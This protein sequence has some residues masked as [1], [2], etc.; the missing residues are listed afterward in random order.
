ML[1]ISLSI[2]VHKLEINHR[3]KLAKQ[4]RRHVTDRK[5]HVTQEIKKSRD[6]GFIKES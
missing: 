6:L 3:A 4:T 2:I 1:G 5:K